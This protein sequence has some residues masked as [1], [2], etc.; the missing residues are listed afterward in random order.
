VVLGTAVIG[1]DIGRSH[2]EINNHFRYLSGLLFG[3]GIALAASIPTIERRS[4]LFTALTF[5]VV[6]GGL[7]RLWG[8]LSYDL[9]APPQMLALTMELGVA[10]LL[11]LWQQ[12]VSLAFRRSSR[13]IRRQAF[14]LDAAGAR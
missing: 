12:R 9:P 11:F 7:A 6:L 14:A 10:P 5:M 8:P 13:R 3:I 2:V 1:G 4:E